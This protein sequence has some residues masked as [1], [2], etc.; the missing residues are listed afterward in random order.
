MKSDFWDNFPIGID[1]LN[2]VIRSIIKLT[3][4]HSIK[5]DENDPDKIISLLDKVL[6]KIRHYPKDDLKKE[7][8][9]IIGDRYDVWVDDFIKALNVSTEGFPSSAKKWLDDLLNPNFGCE[10]VNNYKEIPPEHNKEVWF[11]GKILLIHHDLFKKLADQ[12]N[13]ERKK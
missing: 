2:N 9:N 10:L 3:L 5:I 4:G 7:L 1:H 13:V 6:D 12:L 8:I 11:S